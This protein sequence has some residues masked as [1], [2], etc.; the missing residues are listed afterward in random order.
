MVIMV[1]CF[2]TALMSC[3]MFVYYER[4]MF[5]ES[6]KAEFSSLAEILV[7]KV[8]TPI[9]QDDRPTIKKLLSD[10]RSVES[11]V[12]AGVFDANDV[13][14]ES[15]EKPSSGEYPLATPRAS[16]FDQDFLLEFRPIRDSNG[17][18]LG[19]LYL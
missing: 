4:Y 3:G 18:V 5:R 6:V 10:M 12:A 11:I 1:A 19:T 7:L 9:E 16:S 17:E 14:M 2:I 13:R 15:Y 8:R